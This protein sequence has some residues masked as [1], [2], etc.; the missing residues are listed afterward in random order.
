MARTLLL[1]VLA[2]AAAGPAAQTQSVETYLYDSQG[3]LVGMT[4]ARTGASDR[5]SNYVL[6]D[7]DNW[8]SRRANLVSGPATPDRLVFPEYLVP[9]EEL[10]SPNGQYTLRLEQG[11]DLVLTGPSGPV[12][13]SCTGEGGSLFA[14]VNAQG[15]LGV[16]GTDRVGI[17]STGTPDSPGAKLIVKDTGVVVLESSAG[18]TLWSSTTPCA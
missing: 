14:R 17:W 11:G 16:F 6:D 7:A 10:V 5:I 13:N 9:T 3:R 15:R 12:W 8:I 18:A 1:A 2:A 4:T